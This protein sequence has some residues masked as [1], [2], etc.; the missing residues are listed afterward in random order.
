MDEFEIDDFLSPPFQPDL[1]RK[2]LRVNRV[3]AEN[4]PLGG[5]VSDFLELS[6]DPAEDGGAINL[7]PDSMTCVVI[8]AGSGA[9]EGFVHTSAGS[10]STMDARPG[11]S[12]FV[13]RFFPGVIGSYFG[14]DIK[15]SFGRGLPLGEVI[16]QD[17]AEAL[18]S[19]V[20]GRRGFDAKVEAFEAFF[21]GAAR[22][23]GDQGSIVRFVRDRIIKSSGTVDMASLSRE[24]LY[25][26]RYLRKL[27]EERVGLSRKALCEIVKFQ[28]SFAFSCGTLMT[29]GD[30][31][32]ICGYYDNACMDKAYISLVGMT[33]KRL[34]NRFSL[35]YLRRVPA[36]GGHELYSLRERELRHSLEAFQHEYESVCL[37]RA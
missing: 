32:Q 28:K 25:S 26:D 34:R 9:G 21:H 37:A 15:R 5:I 6:L 8:P 23:L 27:F 18:I 19:A 16:D 7:I 13:A 24:S 29:L 33:P 2:A 36:A 12:Y 17:R 30:I 1:E 11:T 35:E 31:A 14:F 3:V 22:G 20:R 4:S 10:M